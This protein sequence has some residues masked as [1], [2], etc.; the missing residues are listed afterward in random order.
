M[1]FLNQTT[2]TFPSRKHEKDPN[3][4]FLYSADLKLETKGLKYTF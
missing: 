2:F 1:F 3:L 4:L